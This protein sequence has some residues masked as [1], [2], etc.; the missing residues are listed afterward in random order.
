MY[1][2]GVMNQDIFFLFQYIEYVFPLPLTAST[3]EFYAS[4]S[5]GIH[6][7]NPYSFNVKVSFH[8]IGDSYIINVGKVV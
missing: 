6:W 8:L 2:A 1:Q 5:Y 3:N 7:K 4:L